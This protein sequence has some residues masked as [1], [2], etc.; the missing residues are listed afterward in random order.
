MPGLCVLGRIALVAVDRDLELRSTVSGRSAVLMVLILCNRGESSIP[1]LNPCDVAVL[2]LR[3]L[4]CAAAENLSFMACLSLLRDAPFHILSGISPGGA[5]SKVD[6][7]LTVP[8][9]EGAT[10]SCRYVGLNVGTV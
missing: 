10:E 8:D 3:E 9:S 6:S 5:C 7:G 1:D 4:R 2:L